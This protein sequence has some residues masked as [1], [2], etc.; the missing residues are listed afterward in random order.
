[1]RTGKPVKGD[2]CMLYKMCHGDVVLTLMPNTSC[3]ARVDS[4]QTADEFIKQH[5]NRT[6]FYE[7]QFK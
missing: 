3:A 1:M 7:Q 5:I 2:I 4:I 6:E